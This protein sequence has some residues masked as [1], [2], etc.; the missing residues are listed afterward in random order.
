MSMRSGEDMSRLGGGAFGVEED[1][2]FSF[3]FVRHWES[4]ALRQNPGV[5]APRALKPLAILG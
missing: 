4:S 1:R 5:K 3:Y 2:L